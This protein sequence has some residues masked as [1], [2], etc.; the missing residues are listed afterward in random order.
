MSLLLRNAGEYQQGSLLMG[1]TP[2]EDFPDKIKAIAAEHRPSRMPFFQHL[3]ELPKSVADTP[4][5]LGQI[6]L[7]YQAAMYATRAAVYF[8][9]HLNSPAL[10]RSCQC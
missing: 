7:V 2:I 9:P 4:E 1:R 8:M 3:R 5:L 6:Y 10:R